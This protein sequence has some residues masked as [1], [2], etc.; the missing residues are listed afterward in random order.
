[1]DFLS[2]V[3]QAREEKGRE[4]KRQGRANDSIYKSLHLLRSSINLPTN[5]TI[6]QIDFFYCLLFKEARKCIY[7][8]HLTF[9]N[10]HI[11]VSFCHPMS[12]IRG[13]ASAMKAARTNDNVKSLSVVSFTGLMSL[14]YVISLVFSLLLSLV[15]CLN[16]RLISLSSIFVRSLNQVSVS[17]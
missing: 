9:I 10:C 5:I 13:E 7:V 14:P 3:Y 1:L 17:M 12:S 16:L 15:L 6:S 2:K 4:K 8:Y 11:I